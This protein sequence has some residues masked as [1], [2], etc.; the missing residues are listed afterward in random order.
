M[1]TAGHPFL[2]SSY[3]LKNQNLQFVEFSRRQKLGFYAMGWILAVKRV[4]HSGPWYIMGL[5]TRGLFGFSCGIEV[6]QEQHLG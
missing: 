5:W 1:M 2:C 4:S 6:E 3:T